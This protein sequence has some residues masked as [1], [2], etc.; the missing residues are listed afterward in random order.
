MLSVMGGKLEGVMFLCCNNYL[1]S[2]I[3]ID[4]LVDWIL[5]DETLVSKVVSIETK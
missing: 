5:S 4:F 3:S 2:L 1:N